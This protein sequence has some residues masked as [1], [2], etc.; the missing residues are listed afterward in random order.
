MI[1]DLESPGSRTPRPLLDQW[2]ALFARGLLAIAF[3]TLALSWPGA[4]FRQRRWR[5]TLDRVAVIGAS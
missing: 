1:P 2:W 3:A 4:A 5:A